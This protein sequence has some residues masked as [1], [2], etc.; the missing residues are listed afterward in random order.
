MHLPA[1]LRVRLCLYETVVGQ[2]NSLLLRWPQLE[3]AI[4]S[5]CGVLSKLYIHIYIILRNDA[6]RAPAVQSTRI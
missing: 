4:L 5:T 1:E 2:F 3:E 6:K